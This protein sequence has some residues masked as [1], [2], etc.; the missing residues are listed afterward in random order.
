VVIKSGIRIILGAGLL[1]LAFAA[2]AQDTRPDDRWAGLNK[3]EL[4]AAGGRLTAS[5]LCGTLTVPENPGQP[6]G[7]QVELAFAVKPARA[8][9]AQPDPVVFLAG[10]PGQSA[11]DALPIMQGALNELNRERDLVFLD[12][13]GTGG[14]SALDCRFDDQDELWLEP[15]WDEVNR[16][17][18]RCLEGWDANVEFYT[19]TEAAFDL[20]RFRRAYG[21]ERFNLIGGSYGTRLAQVY[22]RNYPD[23]VRSVVLDGVV[24]TRLALGSEHAAMLDRALEK[25]FDDCAETADCAEA[26]PGL[27]QAFADLKARYRDEAVDIVVTHPRTGRGVDLPFSRDTLAGALRFLAYNP[28]TQMMIPYLVHEAERTGSPERLASQAMIVSDRMS[29]MIAIG[30][31]FA[32]G[33]S[34]DWPAWPDDL[35]QSNTL[36]GDSMTEIYEQVCAWWPAGKAP[37]GFHEPFDADVPVL[38]LSGELDPVTPPVYGEEAA[39]QFSD[40]LHLVADGRGHIVITNP[41]MSSIATEFVRDASVGDLDVECMARIGHEPFFLDLLGPSP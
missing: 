9:T 5:A 30:L 31:N 26:F 15:D 41:C 6:D 4:S 11:R 35:D 29:D 17:L 38:L 27:S 33:C 13:R 24:P 34:E 19:S 12:Q 20:D 10:G 36:L 40:S 18:Q 14:S 22:L 3:C 28:E 7:R 2:E 8:S 37:A 25:V 39:E 21:F 16:Q 1:A 32:V 23:H